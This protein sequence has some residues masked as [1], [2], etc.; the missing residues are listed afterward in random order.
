MTALGPVAGRD[1][2]PSSAAAAIVPVADAAECDVEVESDL[3]VELAVGGGA[4]PKSPECSGAA[5][6]G[7]AGESADEGGSGKAAA[8]PPVF[9]RLA[10]RPEVD[11]IRAIAIIPVV[12]Y[13]FQL[14][15]PG[16]FAGVDVFFVISG[17]L[18]TCIVLSDL[19]R[20][21]FSMKRFCA[22]RV[23]RLFPAL[24]FM[25]V[26]LFIAASY[27]LLQTARGEPT[28]YT[29]MARSAWWTLLSVANFHWLIYNAGYFSPNSESMPLL[30]M[31]S[32]AVEEQFYLLHPL[33]L[34][35]VWRRT[36]S[37]RAVFIAL[38]VLCAGSLAFSIAVV[39]GSFA[40]GY[41][42]LPSR[43][44]EMALGGLLAF[45]A[46]LGDDGSFCGR[47]N[48]K[49]V[50]A[51]VASWG[52]VGMII[53]SCFIFDKN[54][55]WPSYPALLPC[56]G[57][58][59]FIAAERVRPT[60]C[61]RLFALRPVVFVGQL[62]Y[63]WYLW[64]WPVYV[65]MRTHTKNLP[66]APSLPLGLRFAGVAVSFVASV[67]SY[68]T[69][70]RVFRN[71][72]GFWSSDKH[73]LSLAVCVWLLLMAWSATA[74]QIRG[75]GGI[76]FVDRSC[77][78]PPDNDG[79]DA[80]PAPLP[81][82]DAAVY[83]NGSTCIPLPSN[84]TIQQR[85]HTTP[86]DLN[87]LDLGT[88]MNSKPLARFIHCVSQSQRYRLAAQRWEVVSAHVMGPPVRRWPPGLN[89][90]HPTIALIGSSVCCERT[91]FFERL[92][93][94]YGMRVGVLCTS[95]VP[96]TLGWPGNRGGHPDPSGWDAW[97]LDHIRRWKPDVVVWSDPFTI[98]TEY[99]GGDLEDLM[100]RSMEGFLDA[101]AKKLVILGDVP[102]L[103]Q[104]RRP[105]WETFA[106]PEYRR[107]GN[108]SFLG[109]IKNPPSPTI[110]RHEAMVR[111]VAASFP[112]GRVHVIRI[113]DYFVDAETDTVSVVNKDTGRMIFYD[114]THMTSD[115]YPR[116]DE[117]ISSKV[118]GIP[119]CVERNE[120]AGQP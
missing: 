66:G 57:T 88:V 49:R 109:Q 55:P 59:L 39:P 104:A 53:A 107:T 108:F 69:V 23:R 80:C 120:S 118:F 26:P 46:R 25:L 87:A 50:V 36:H 106:Y 4:S 41:Y 65:L 13:H 94:R 63:S 78:Y 14:S 12:M 16:G 74:S 60:F 98:L 42:M 113:F 75:L 101:G 7:P 72:K 21:K 1:R 114:A 73:F 33:L 116:L 117:L 81:L 93:N 27:V 44:W 86:L 35:G 76:Y 102:Y 9:P 6:G 34:W 83:V 48:K 51:E 47:G 71:K 24:A 61:G 112:S 96:G 95:A 15:F 85:A 11:G 105:M 62:S 45:E 58:M 2:Q 56:A 64:H 10:Y 22:R 100:R 111:R 91:A 18:I 17:Y 28:E 97:R 84:A 29:E 5:E 68:F 92:A 67:V 89:M 54:T 37:P 99:S 40:V 110:V 19:G 79:P 3:S 103:S 31:W 82:G 8:P 20:D 119:A 52:G 77:P 70:E 32:L 90:E 30:H 115:A 38:T 43:A